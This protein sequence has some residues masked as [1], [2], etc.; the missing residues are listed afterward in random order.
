MHLLPV[1]HWEVARIFAT[2]LG[3]A[4]RVASIKG[5]PQTGAALEPLSAEK[6]RQAVARK[7]DL[8]FRYWR[9]TNWAFLYGNRQQT[10][11]SR[12]HENPGRRWFPEELQKVLPHLDEAEQRI[13]QAA[14]AA[15]R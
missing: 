15:S 13:H 7:N 8:W 3:V 14:K 5:P 1:G 4:N 10:P 6:L 12:D 9:P 11:S 2:Q